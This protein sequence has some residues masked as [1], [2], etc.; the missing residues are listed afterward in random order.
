MVRAPLIVDLIYQKKKNK[1]IT[2][3]SR[4]VH[5]S[6]LIFLRLNR[7]NFIMNEK[8]KTKICFDHNSYVAAIYMTIV[9][10]IHN[11]I[12]KMIK[13][14]KKQKQQNKR[15]FTLPIIIITVF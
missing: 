14:T 8:K 9:C 11:S 15:R 7:V 1:C 3:C 2:E 6:T 12:T 5:L 10:S 13:S 4:F